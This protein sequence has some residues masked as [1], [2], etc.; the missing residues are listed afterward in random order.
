MAWT[1]LAES[2]DS[3]L[4]WLPGSSQLP[5]VKTTD[6]QELF[7]CPE[8]GMANFHMR[9]S[10]MISTLSHLKCCI[11]KSTL[12][13][14]DSH[15]RMSVK[16]ELER[17]WKE[18]EPDFSFKQL[19]LFENVDLP[20]YSLKMFQGLK[21]SYLP[22]G[23][24]LRNL[25]TL[26]GTD[27]LALRKLGHLILD[28][29]GGFLPT[30]TASGFTQN[31]SRNKNA[32]VRLSLVGMARKNKWPTPKACEGKGGVFQRK[33][34]DKRGLSLTAQ[35]GG[36]LNPKWIEWL[37]GYPLG[38]TV[39]EAWAMQWFRCKLKKHLKD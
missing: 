18:S 8:C 10:G 7:F 27:S 19:D 22:L 34:G 21:N 12:F 31:K 15:V 33:K 17:A 24:S 29:D 23:P 13:M 26:V 20:S 3:L 35:V 38:W 16:Q 4:P 30:P 11:R 28:K 2:E 5:I 25:D 39:L 32:K 9:T 37:M 6:M 36:K 14:E 1:Y